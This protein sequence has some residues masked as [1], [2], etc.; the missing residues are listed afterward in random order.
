MHHSSATDK[1]GYLV[2]I[3]FY[4]YQPFTGKKKK[5]CALGTHLDRLTKATQLS[6]NTGFHHE[7]KCMAERIL[8]GYVIIRLHIVELGRN[9]PNY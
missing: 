5:K 1:S 8:A 6:N 3:K 9:Y 2:K 7:K 4:T